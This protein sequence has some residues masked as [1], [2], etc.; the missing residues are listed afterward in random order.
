MLQDIMK[1]YFV[2]QKMNHTEQINVLK[3]SD[4]PK[5]PAVEGLPPGTLSAR[6]CL[7]PLGGPARDLQYV[8]QLKI[9]L[10]HYCIANE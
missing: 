3:A 5:Y 8:Q 10:R 4:E 2:R 9:F 1:S 6:L 7:V